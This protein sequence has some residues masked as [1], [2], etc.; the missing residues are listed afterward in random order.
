[1]PGT[2]RPDFQRTKQQIAALRK[3]DRRLQTASEQG[4]RLEQA[5]IDAAAAWVDAKVSADLDGFDVEELNRDKSGIRVGV[6]RAVVED[7]VAAFSR[8][9]PDTDRALWLKAANVIG[10]DAFRE[11][12]HEQLSVMKDCARRGHPLRNPAAAFQKKLKALK[13]KGGAA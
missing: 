13:P 1:M 8:R 4:A 11:L 2:E 12:F 7:A 10:W 9:Q 3:L 6:L 5:V